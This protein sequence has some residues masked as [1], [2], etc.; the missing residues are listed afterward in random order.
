M[1]RAKNAWH[2]HTTKHGNAKIKCDAKNE[3]E[4]V[5]SLKREKKKKKQR[6][7]RQMKAEQCGDGGRASTGI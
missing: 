6:Q 3:I 4:T 2:K 5:E 1:F 7:Q